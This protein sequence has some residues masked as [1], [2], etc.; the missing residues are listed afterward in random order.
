MSRKIIQ[1]TSCAVPC[2]PSYNPQ[3][4][5]L[6]ALCDDG[7]VFRLWDDHPGDWNRV[8]PIPQDEEQEVKP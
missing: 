5:V 1:I 8:A 7:S 3:L 6:Y 2:Q 4:F